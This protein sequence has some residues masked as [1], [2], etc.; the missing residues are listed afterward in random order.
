MSTNHLLAL[1]LQTLRAAVDKLR[2]EALPG[3][4]PESR[5]VLADLMAQRADRIEDGEDDHSEIFPDSTGL[6]AGGTAA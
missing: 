5:G 6:A 4:D 3:L 2:E 1:K